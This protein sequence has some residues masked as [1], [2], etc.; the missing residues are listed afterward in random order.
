[1]KPIVG[2]IGL[3]IMGSAMATVP[4]VTWPCV[5]STMAKAPVPATSQ[6]LS[7]ISVT[8]NQVLS[9]SASWKRPVCWSTAS[10]T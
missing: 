6:A 5:H 7:R 2:V 4:T 8:V 3:G 9:R 10:R 1:M